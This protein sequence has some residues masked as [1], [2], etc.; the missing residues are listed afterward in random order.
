ML[1]QLL[2]TKTFCPICRAEIPLT[3]VNVATDIALCRHCGKTSSFAEAIATQS[4]VPV[5]LARPP[6]GTWLSRHG[7]GFEL[8]VSTRSP[9]AFFLVPFMCVWSGGSLGGIYGSQ[10]ARG[11]F[12]FGMSLFGLPFLIGTLVFGSIAIMSVCGKI[13]IRIE[14]SSV[15]FDK[16][17][18]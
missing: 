4:A 3:D 17:T 9:I 2:N 11:H 6:K 15:V 12:N 14:G 16:L 13:S 8:G 1:T 5:D 18:A 10:I 7:N